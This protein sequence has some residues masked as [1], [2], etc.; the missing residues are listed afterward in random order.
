MVLVE[1]VAAVQLKNITKRFGKVIANNSVSLD[2][3]RGEILSLL[4]ENG[5]GKTTLMNMLAGIYFPDEGEILVNGKPVTIAS[6]KDAFDNGIGMIHQH[7]KL[8]D[9]FTAA[10]NIVLGLEEEGKLDLKAA[11]AKITEICGKYGFQIDPNKKIY[12]MSVSEKQTV[13]IVKVLYR[14]AEI[15]ILDEP[16]AVL[17]PQETDRLFD[18]MRNMKADGKSM[19]IIT[20]KLHEVMDVSDRV[21]VLRKGKYIGDVATSE[22]NPQALTDMMVGHAVTL[23]I[24]RPEPKNPIPRLTVNGLTVYDALGVKR[25]DNVSFT[26]MGGEILGIAGIAGSGQKELLESIA[27]LQPLAPG[28]SITY[29]P[30][31]SDSCTEL[32]GK[33]P[34]QI[35]QAG[36]SLAFVPEDRLGMGLVGTMGMTGNMLLRSYRKG[37]GIFT[38]RKSPKKLAEEVLHELDV[39]T[40]NVNFPVRRLSGGNVQKVLVGREIAQEPS[41]LMTAYA[42]RGL[43][44][45]TS[46]T[47]YNLLTE[48]KM[49]GVAV[50][51]VGEDLDVL[52]E[53]CDRILVLCGGQVSGIVDARTTTKEEVGLLMTRFKKEA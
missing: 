44:I 31:G 32:V 15:L 20:H 51:Y 39:V 47:I 22:T 33:T 29:C 9:V 43:D 46:Y 25:L 52:L 21:A 5:S 42:V 40:P 36:V 28:A 24:N 10:E 13:E 37:K 53:L 8:V 17:T 14:G 49:K 34:L 16:T 35:K 50:V 3:N 38:D 48:Q 7:F 27:G 12:D 2:I 23:N 4:G 1:T 45:N 41:V 18:V 11:A 19:V 30:M 26:A 6:P